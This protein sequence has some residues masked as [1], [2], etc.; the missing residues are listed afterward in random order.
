MIEYINHNFS[1]GTWYQ[2]IML[3]IIIV[4]LVYANIV[5]IKAGE[6]KKAGVG[7]RKRDNYKD[8]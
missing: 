5:L 1:V 6:K 8:A 3:Y 7:V 2:N 4:G